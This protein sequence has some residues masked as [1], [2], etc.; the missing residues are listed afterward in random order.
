[1]VGTIIISSILLSSC[2]QDKPPKN[3]PVLDF[4]CHIAQAINEISF[5]RKNVDYW[6]YINMVGQILTVIFGL[7][8]TLIIAMQTDKN[9]R[10]TRPVGI[11]ATTFVTGISSVIGN[12]H[13]IENVDKMVDLTCEMA[14]LTNIYYF[15]IEDLKGGRAKEEIDKAYKEDGIFRNKVNVTTKNF[16]TELNNVKLEMLRVKGTVRPIKEKPPDK[17][18]K[19]SSNRT[20]G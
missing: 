2:I 18:I 20:G 3:C 12:F 11:I 13:V 4:D 6:S 15:E 16:C 5:A 7:I 10:W 9:K 1:M 8:A 17:Q 19:S 14:T